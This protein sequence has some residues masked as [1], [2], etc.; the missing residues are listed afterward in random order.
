M[1]QFYRHSDKITIS[2]SVSHSDNWAHSNLTRTVVPHLINIDQ[3][4]SLLE[5]PLI[6]RADDE[7][8]R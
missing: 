1:L 8:K 6:K 2:Q 5:V 4:Q 3:R 7:A